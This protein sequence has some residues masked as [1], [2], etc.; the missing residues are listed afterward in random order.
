MSKIK[1]L[2]FDVEL[3]INEDKKLEEVKKLEDILKKLIIVNVNIKM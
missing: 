3:E 2:L 1:N